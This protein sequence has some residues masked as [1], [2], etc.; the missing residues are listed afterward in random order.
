[1]IKK[2]ALRIVTVL[3]LLVAQGAIFPI[4]LPTCLIPNLV[5]IVVVALAC[6]RVTPMGALQ[7]FMLG[8]LFDLISARTLIGP[9]AAA[10]TV[11]FGLVSLF[12]QRLF[13]ESWLTIAGTVFSAVMVS[14]LVYLVLVSQFARIDGFLL[15]LLTLTPFEAL[16]SA[17]FAPFLFI[18]LKPW[19]RPAKGGGMDGR[20]R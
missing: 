20:W 13:L 19:L 7:A 1:M 5:V 3:L 15:E 11:V 14:E 16:V 8:L 2:L 6:Y 9:H 12:S 17:I 4:F 18:I 10:C